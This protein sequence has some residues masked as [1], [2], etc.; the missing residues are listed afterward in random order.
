MSAVRATIDLPASPEDVWALIMDPQRLQAWVTIHRELVSADD[1]PPRHGFRMT[2]RMAIRG[3]PVTV[4]WTLDE[5]DAPRKATWSGAGPAGST[6]SIEYRLEA[7]DAGTRFH[8]TNDFRP[9]M[10][11]LGKVASRALMGGTPDREAEASLQR[12]RTLF[13]AG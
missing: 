12:L 1:G 6:A 10:G 11:L 8:Y 4:T 7:I 5:V 3:A 9:P 2:Q 13:P